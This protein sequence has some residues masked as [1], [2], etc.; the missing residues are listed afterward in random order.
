VASFHSFFLFAN[1]SATGVVNLFKLK[2]N[3]LSMSVANKWFSVGH[4]GLK[5]KHRIEG[6]LSAFPFD[7][8][9]TQEPGPQLRKD[10]SHERE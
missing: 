3:P 9:S 1:L 2:T 5:G 10:R 8:K 4:R 7:G 6:S